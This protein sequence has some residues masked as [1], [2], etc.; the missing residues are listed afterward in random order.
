[1]AKKGDSQMAIDRRCIWNGSRPGWVFKPKR[2]EMQIHEM[3]DELRTGLW[4][5]I[6]IAC[7][8]RDMPGR[9]GSAAVCEAHL[10]LL[11][12]EIQ[13][14]KSRICGTGFVTE[15]KQRFFGYQWYEVYDFIEGNRGHRR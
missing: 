4:N 15:S 9:H 11:F 1:M 5:L 12:C 2:K 7:L 6:W 13:L 3:S 10:A 14:M 8:N